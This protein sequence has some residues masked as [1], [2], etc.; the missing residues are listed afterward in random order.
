MFARNEVGAAVTMPALS[1]IFA[2][3]SM[4]WAPV[5]EAMLWL[6]LVIAAKVLLI[7]NCRRFLLQPRE[8]IDLASWRRRITLSEAINGMTWAGF[9]LVGV[10]VR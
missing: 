10:R 9:A 4:F 6:V 7:E 5:Q 3:A 8:Q 1:V 2:L